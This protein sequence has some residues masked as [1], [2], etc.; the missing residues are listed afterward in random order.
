MPITREVTKKLWITGFL[1]GKKRT[2][3]QIAGKLGRKERVS[4]PIAVSSRTAW[5]RKTQ[6]Q[7]TKA[8]IKRKKAPTKRSLG[9][10]KPLGRFFTKTKGAART[11]P[12]VKI[13]PTGE[14]KLR[15][16]ASISDCSSPKGAGQNAYPGEASPGGNDIE[17]NADYGIIS[18][19]DGVSTVVPTLQ[20]KLG[21]SPTVI[22][23]AEIDVSLRALVCAEFGYRPD[24][25]WGRTKH[26]SASLYVKDVN[27]LLKDNCRCLHEAISIAPNAK[28][29]IVGGSPC[30]DLTFAGPHRVGLVGKSSRLFLPS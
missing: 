28:W 29:I 25:T 16:P 22:V 12:I 14:A 8:I 21:Q 24:Q 20:K 4:V 27:S 2:E 15:E 17:I 9:G 18:L 23:L 11:K 7:V 30:Q 10:Q 1:L 3:S 26:G 5:L 13:N 6:Q 19:F